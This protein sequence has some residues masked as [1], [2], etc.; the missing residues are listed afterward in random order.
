MNLGSGGERVG[1]VGPRGLDVGDRTRRDST[2]LYGNP[3]DYPTRTVQGFVILVEI[4]HN[5]LVVWA[6]IDYNRS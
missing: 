3:D 4:Q 2:G 6:R 5:T 1:T